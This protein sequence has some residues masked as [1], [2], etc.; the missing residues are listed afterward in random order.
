MN[1]R[2]FI[3]IC[4]I[5]FSLLVSSTW[6]DKIQ[7]YPIEDW[8][9]RADMQNVSLSPDGNKL[10]LLKIPSAEENPILEVY[11]ANNLSKKPFRMNANPMEITRFYWATDDKIIF[12]ARQVVRK[13]IDGFNDG[14]YKSSSAILTLH[15][16]PKKSKP[17]RK[18]RELGTGGIVG[19]I[20]GKPNK[21]LVY[22]YEK[23]S[24]SPIYYEYDVKTRKREMITRESENVYRFIFDG[25]GNPQFAQGYS[26]ASEEYLTYYRN[27]ETSGWDVINRMHRE[28]FEYWRVFGVDPLNPDDLLVV[29][30]NGA[31]TAG[32]WSFDPKTKKYKELIYRRTDGD[33]FPVSHSNEYQYPDLITGVVYRDGRDQKYEWFDGEEKALHEQLMALIPNSDRM[34][35]SS[36]SRDGNSMIV[37]NFG[38]RDPGTYYLVKNGAIKVIGSRMPWFSSDRLA[39]VK[40]IKYKSR[41]GKLVRGFITIP[42]SDGPHPLVVMPHGGPFVAE[43]PSYDGWAQLLANY[44]YLVLQPQYRGSRG[45]GLDFYKSAFID[46]GEGGFKMQDDKDDG[47]LYLV[48]QGLV[49]PDRMAMFG[50]SYGGYAALIAASREDQIYQCAIAGAAVADNLQ[51]LN[52]YKNDITAFRTSGSEEQIRMWEDSISPIKEVE[53][54]NIPL[55][56]IHGDVDQRVPPKHARKYLAA[57][58]KA[59]IPHKSLWLE[60]ADHFSD[61]LFYHHNVKFYTELLDFLDNDCFPKDGSLALK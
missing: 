9:K 4:C 8:A 39:D 44:G 11:D 57:L 54:V 14:V 1:D 51:Q 56:V 29:A 38:P 37:Q 47:A 22:A 59:G 3:F 20:P 36:R 42:N 43:N 46:G 27:K 6:A 13:K 5:F 61:T 25:Y 17:P 32:L 52:Y 35:I 10:A 15:K 30:H 55:F 50:W 23:G 28:N 53:K 31:N 18:L 58:E 41:D 24:F 7:P 21:F 45:Y 49:D 2:I 12:S 48:E 40:E 19:P 33:V 60:G 26:G 16:D 34:E